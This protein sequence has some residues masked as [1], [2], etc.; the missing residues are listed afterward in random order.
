MD[1]GEIEPWIVRIECDAK[2]NRR[3]IAW[4]RTELGKH[5]GVEGVARG[6]V[7]EAGGLVHV[8][9]IDLAE[10]LDKREVLL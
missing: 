4:V 10:H 2:A 3:G 1:G 5:V 8:T 9:P 7:V 6:E